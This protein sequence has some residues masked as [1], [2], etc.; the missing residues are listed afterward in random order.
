MITIVVGTKAELIKMMPIM[1]ELDKEK[2]PYYFIHTGQHNLGTLI[3]DFDLKKPDKI[4]FKEPKKSSRFMVRLSK[5][6]FWFFKFI[7]KIKKELSKIKAS[8]VLYHG[9]TESSAA[10]AIASSLF[11]NPFKKYKNVHVEAGLR[12]FDLFE[13]FPEEISRRICDKFSNVL[14]AVSET[15]KKNLENE[16]TFGKIIL[17]GNTIYDSIKIVYNKGKRMYKKDKEKY[18]LISVHR[19]EN[20]KSK[21]RLSKIV[22]IIESINIKAYWPM[23]DNTK[24]QLIKFGLLRKIKKKD[25]IL[26]DKPWPYSKFI[27]YLANSKYV[28]VDGG[29]IQEE[30]LAFKIPA[31][32]LRMK[33]ERV[34]GLKTGL[35][36]LTKLNVDY[37]RKLIRKCEEGKIKVKKFKNPYLPVKS[38]SKKI[39]EY[40]MENED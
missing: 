28:V 8:F 3:K 12:S 37:G 26:I 6:S 1:K 2:I 18:C 34:E 22:E 23:H 19:H 29:S 9:D 14:F 20:I 30:S 11:L 40:L 35:N 5:A 4:L 21:K 25:N 32:L 38:P 10:T 16:L 33:T 13:P 27:F 31:I 36:F 17:T 7:Y 24:Q 15:A 39:V